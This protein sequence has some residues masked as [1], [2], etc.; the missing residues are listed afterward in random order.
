L[1]SAIGQVPDVRQCVT[2]DL[3]QA[4]NALYILGTTKN[5]LGGSHLGI[6]WGRTFANVPQVD[7][8]TARRTFE[9]VHRA[10]RAGLVRAC[11]DLSEGGLAVGLAEM[12]F[13][14]ALG[15][16]IDLRRVPH[17]CDDLSPDDRRTAI[18]FAESNSR[19]ICEVP[20]KHCDQFEEWMA[21]AEVACGALGNVTDEP[22]LMIGDG[23]EQLLQAPC[24]A[25]K[26]SWQFPLRW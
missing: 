6:V 3:K 9:V 24:S 13:A 14:G 12:A 7:A 25:L 16:H 10:V 18:L 11:H 17:D 20:A 26:E 8:A 15:A 22:A 1:I 19:F 4:G 23:D 21:G 2:M 5:E